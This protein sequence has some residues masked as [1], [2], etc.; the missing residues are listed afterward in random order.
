MKLIIVTNP[1]IKPV[2]KAEEGN[3]LETTDKIEG[4]EHVYII[5]GGNTV[6]DIIEHLDNLY[7]YRTVTLTC[8]STIPAFSTMDKLFVHIT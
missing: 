2:G 4:L 8:T 1:A 5:G 6:V 7:G 3:F